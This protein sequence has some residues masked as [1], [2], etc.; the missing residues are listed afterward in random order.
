M[1]SPIF[2]LHRG[3]LYRYNDPAK[4]VRGLSQFALM[5]FKDQRGHRVPE[6]PTALEHFYEHAKERIIDALVILRKTSHFVGGL[7][8]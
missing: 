3:K 4:D 7:G 5:K 8:R 2:R 6:P 1:G